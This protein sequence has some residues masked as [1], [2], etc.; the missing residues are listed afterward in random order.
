MKTT[1]PTKSQGVG[2]GK[3]GTG[4]GEHHGGEGC[5]RGEG[6]ECLKAFQGHKF[7]FNKNGAS[8]TGKG[9]LLNAWDLGGGMGL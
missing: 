6:G 4:A 9:D 1:S 7:H 8:L 2:G 5:T 3:G